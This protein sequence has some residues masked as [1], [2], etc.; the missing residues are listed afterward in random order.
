LVK[1]AGTP[2]SIEDECEYVE[3][4]KPEELFEKFDPITAD[5]AYVRWLGDCKGIE[6]L[7]TTWDKVVVDRTE[8]LRNWVKLLRSLVTDKRIR[9]I[10]AFMNN[11]FSGHAPAGI[12]LFFDLWNEK[13]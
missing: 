4:P 12:K 5:F 10:L 6:E 2:I 7:T 3:V 1:A 13:N 8:D 9:K 11:H